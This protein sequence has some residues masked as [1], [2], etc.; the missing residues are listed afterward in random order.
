MKAKITLTPN[1]TQNRKEKFPTDDYLAFQHFTVW[2]L[3]N[4]LICPVKIILDLN[5]SLHAVVN[6]IYFF[7]SLI[8]NFKLES[9]NFASATKKRK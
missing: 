8:F 2:L 3:Q 1:L 7:R 5:L 6:L 4:K 9:K